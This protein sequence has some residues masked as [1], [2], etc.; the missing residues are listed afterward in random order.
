MAPGDKLAISSDGPQHGTFPEGLLE[1]L[2][3]GTVTPQAQ[4]V[5]EYSQLTDS[6]SSLGTV[7]SEN[8]AVPQNSRNQSGAF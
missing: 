7:S 4:V 1:Q 3:L 5:P 2:F 8:T 6:W